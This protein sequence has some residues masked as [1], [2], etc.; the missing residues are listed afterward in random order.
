MQDSKRDVKDALLTS[1][2]RVIDCSN[3]VGFGGGRAGG[4]A[5]VLIWGLMQ[6][7]IPMFELDELCMNLGW[8]V[9]KI[10]AWVVVVVGA[11]V[12]F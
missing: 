4:I 11:D 5:V 10:L 9:G 12:S 6:S 7:N 3:A 1:F 8:G 2:R